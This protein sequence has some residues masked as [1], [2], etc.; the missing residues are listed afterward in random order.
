MT[1][2]ELQLMALLAAA[3]AV[4]DRWEDIDPDTGDADALSE[5]MNALAEVVARVKEEECGD[6]DRYPCICGDGPQNDDHLEADRGPVDAHQ[7]L[8]MARAM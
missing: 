5:A 1:A 6:C 4:L 3:D 2:T 7:L 8:M